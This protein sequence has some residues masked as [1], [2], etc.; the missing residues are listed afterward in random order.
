MKAFLLLLGLTVLPLAL[1]GEEF[2]PLKIAPGAT[3]E[4]DFRTAEL[5][6][7][8]RSLIAPFRER[9]AG[10]PWLEEASQFIREAIPEWPGSEASSAIARLSG[11]GQKLLRAGCDDPLIGYFATWARWTA[12]SEN[13][14]S[15][16]AFSKYRKA[17]EKLPG[18]SALARMATVDF[19]RANAVVRDAPEDAAKKYA[20]LSARAWTDGSYLPEEGA[21]YLRHLGMAVDDDVLKKLDD[22]MMQALQPAEL[23]PWV[24]ETLVGKAEI[25]R[26][27]AS[28]GNEHADKVTQEGA[29]GFDEH[30]EKAHRHLLHAWQLKKDQPMAATLLITV[31]MGGGAPEQESAR[32]WFDRAVAAQCDYRAAYEALGVAL[33]PRWGGSDE[34]LLA[35]AQA[36]LAT[37][38]FDTDIPLFFLSTLRFLKVWLP[39][40]MPDIRD[41]LRRPE[42]APLA[43]QCLHGCAEE[44]S[45]ADHRPVWLAQAALY[46]WLTNDATAAGRTLAECGPGPLPTEVRVALRNF[47]TDE[48]GFRGELAILNSPA[49]ELYLSATKQRADEE[50]PRAVESFQRAAGLTQG[51]AADRLRALA[52][53]AQV[54][55]TL[56]TGDWATVP[57]D[58]T[59][60]GW[61]QRAGAWSA[62]PEGYPL[63]REGDGPVRVT[64]AARVGRDFEMRATLDVSGQPQ[65]KWFTGLTYSDLN[66]PGVVPVWRGAFVRFDPGKKTGTAR[67]YSPEFVIN[68]PDV[69]CPLLAR[70]ETTLRYESGNITWT[71]NGKQIHSAAKIGGINAFG[72]LGFGSY[73]HTAGVT[74]S[75][76]KM[77]IR[78]LGIKDTP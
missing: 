41:V 61:I 49:R 1:Y 70:N 53:V 7:A 43:R 52:G 16:A 22:R 28:R 57:P 64:Y 58:P 35:L 72:M 54:E 4:R 37:Q 78:R 29:R 45:R 46:D 19:L 24:H 69:E 5:A 27:W 30:L 8:E 39:G 12:T 74:I 51:L 2:A 33:L 32:L 13:Y 20:E 60:S 48:N 44:K 67:C 56:T 47:G 10:Q 73:K 21:I 14:G 65:A 38:R 42:I 9:A 15:R 55:A 34:E 36:C 50:Y 63:L 76:K 66:F 71:F 59:L 68:L 3:T 62:T 11:Q 18:Q 40:Q 77:E 26:A 31:A 25:N 17:A 6:W 75:L 23:P